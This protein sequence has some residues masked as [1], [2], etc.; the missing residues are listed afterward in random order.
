MKLQYPFARH[1]LQ[2]TL[3]QLSDIN[4]QEE[5]WVRAD[6]S[7]I[8]DYLGY[9]FAM[10]DLLDNVIWEAGEK[11]IGSIFRNREEF[12]ACLAV[13]QLA[14]NFEK[15]KQKNLSDEEY[16]SDA[17]WLPII[18]AARNALRVLNAGDL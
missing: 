16:I 14:L 9:D 3:L 6:K 1:N 7:V 5:A 2:V 12:E 18:A 13:F 17:D 15:S 8:K 10:E 11:L 4:Y